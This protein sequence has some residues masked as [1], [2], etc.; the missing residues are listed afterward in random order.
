MLMEN[1]LRSKEYWD[2]VESGVAEPTARMSEAQKAELEAL[3]LKDLKAKNYLFQAIDRTILETILCKDTSKQIW[4]SMK[5][6][7]MAILNKLRTH[8]DKTQDVT[9]VEK[10]LRSMTPKYNFVI[11]AIEE[12]N[13][14]MKCHLKNLKVPC[15]YMKGK[16]EAEVEEEISKLSFLKEEEGGVADFRFPTD[17]SQQISPKLSAFGATRSNKNLWYLD[18]G[19]SNHMCRDKAAFFPLDESFK[20]NVK[21]GDNSKVSVRGRGQVTIQIRGNAA[22]T[23]SNV[24][25]VPELKTNLLSIGQLQEKGYEIIIKNGVCRIQDSKFGL[26]AQVK[27]TANRMFPLHLNCAS[28]SCFSVKTNDVAWLW[29]SRY[30]HLNF[31]GLKQL[32]QKN[33]VTGLPVFESPS[34]VCEECV[35]SKQHRD[36]FPKGRSTRARRLLE[37]VYPDI[38]G[39]INPVSNGVNWSIHILNRSPTFAIQNMT[40]EEAWSGRKPGVDHFKIF[41]CIAYAHIL[42]EK[43]KKLDDKG[44]KS[45]FLG[46]SNNSKAYKRYNP[47]TKKIIVSRDVIFD[48]GKFWEWDEGKAEQKISIGFDGEIEEEKQQQPIE[49]EQQTSENQSIIPVAPATPPTLIPEAE[50]DDGQRPQRVRKRPTWMLDYEAMDEEIA[51]IERNNSWELTELPKGK[52]TI[53]VKWVYKTK[54][55]ENGEVDKYKARLVAKGYKQEFGVDYQEVFAP[56]ARHDTI[57]LVISLA[58]QNSWPVFQ[59]DVKS[60]FLHGDL[61]E[62]VFIEQPPGYVKVGNEHKVYKLKR[63]LY[64]LKQAPRA[65]YSR[66]EAYFLN[67]GFQKCPYEHTL[68]TKIEGGKMLIVCLYVDDLIYTGN[69]KA[70][71]DQLKKSMMAEFDMSDLGL[72]HYYLGIEVDQYAA[73]I[74]ISQKKYVQDILDRFRMKDCNPVSTPIDAGMKLVKNPEGKKVNSTLY[75][76]IVGSLMYLTATRPDIMHA[77]SLISR[78][79]ESPKEMHLLA[80][81]RILRYLKGTVEYGLFYKKREKSDMFGFT[82][83]DF[84]RDVDDRKSTYGYVFMMGTAAV[85]WSSR[86]QPIVTLS[87]TEVEFVAATSCACQAIWLLRILEECHFKQEEPLIIFCDSNSTI[88]LSKNPILH[89]RCKHIDVR[90]YFLKDLVK[91]GVID[92]SKSGESRGGIVLLV[93]GDGVAEVGRNEGGAID[94]GI[95]GFAD[96]SAYDEGF[97]RQLEKERVEEFVP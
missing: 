76:Q 24:F 28:Q 16:E 10:I 21:F 15:W 54:L 23:I 45:I 7:T 27:M 67:E 91:E 2:V 96:G 33:M 94:N 34:T 62:Q 37:I 13:D 80:A 93:G 71:F 26:I 8:G 41:G 49:N 40:L 90:N 42:D 22:Q 43:R 89:G 30:G 79:M 69:D 72:M 73:G 17:Q 9:V 70:M 47:N 86:K 18:T 38:C 46:V 29:H 82:N 20:D 64:G 44:E 77:V 32:Q 88:K 39:P 14:L 97:D 59:L 12:A 52:K 63:A 19:C 78:Y 81:K 11:C 87:T 84:A 95:P 65:W 51:T 58:A 68:F 55:K 74:F 6:K 31:G 75:K 60:A 3:K 61:D 35:V 66:I 36:P 57:R 85:S 4:D 53:G 25:Y 56:V 92:L 83:S 48:E 1:F 50:S 5:K